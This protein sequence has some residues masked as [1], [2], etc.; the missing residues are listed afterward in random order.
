MSATL[1]DAFVRGVLTDDELDQRLDLAMNA[2]DLPAL[3]RLTAD[4]P[5][6]EPSPASTALVPTTPST[7]LAHGEASTA[8]T[9]AR[10]RSFTSVL[11]DVDD[12]VV[13]GE[14]SGVST[15]AI[16]A[17]IDLRFELAE[18]ARGGTTLLDL[19]VIVGDIKL[20]VPPDVLVINEATSILGDIGAGKKRRARAPAPGDA[21]HTLI[22]RGFVLLGE[23]RI[24]STR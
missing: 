17:D 24:R 14:T 20:R 8:L 19:S 15:L 7:A 10:P 23:V 18:H 4:I 16:L 5:G 9:V 13:L 3:A 22:L 6:V 21:A 11:G 1:Q 12:T 2:Q